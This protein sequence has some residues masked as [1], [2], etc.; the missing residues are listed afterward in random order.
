AD[1][2]ADARDRELLVHQPR[3]SLKGHEVPRKG[4]DRHGLPDRHREAR[5]EAAA[6]SMI[7]VP[8]RASWAG[9][10]SGRQGPCRTCAT[11]GALTA[12]AVI[13]ATRRAAAITE[14][15]IVSRWIGGTGP[16]AGA[17]RR[18]VSRRRG[19]PGKSD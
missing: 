13:T 2:G 17:T 19:E 6:R 18:R 12:P 3:E 4:V 16:R 14:G 8:S 11:T 1:A 7:Q 15:V 5:A 10:S 9:S